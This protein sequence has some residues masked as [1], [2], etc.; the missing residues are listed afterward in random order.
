MTGIIVE[1]LPFGEP[2]PFPEP[3]KCT[4]E[5][6]THQEFKEWVQG[7]VCVHC[8][9]DFLDFRGKEPETL[10]DW[11]NMGCGCE[12]EVTDDSNLI[13]WDDKMIKTDEIKSVL[14]DYK[15]NISEGE[16]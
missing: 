15:K 11:L 5:F 10:A 2:S 14:E 3:D 12:I 9:V 16:E 1:Y 13:N 8:L 4:W 7:Y 6:K